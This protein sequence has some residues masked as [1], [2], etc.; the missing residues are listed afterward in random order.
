[1]VGM[2]DSEEEED[3]KFLLG[4]DPDPG[5]LIKPCRVHTLKERVR[6][7]AWRKWRR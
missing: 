6:N 2:D 3:L 5:A 1:M 7:Q 4:K